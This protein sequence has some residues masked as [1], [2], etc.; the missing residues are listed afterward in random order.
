ME[1]H[2]CWSLTEN[3]NLAV[4]LDRG[5]ML[6]Y[7]NIG[8]HWLRE[9]QSARL[10]LAKEGIPECL[11]SLMRYLQNLSEFGVAVQISQ[12]RIFANIGIA[13]ETRFNADPQYM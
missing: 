6:M 13:E 9:K 11:V 7:A 2:T 4:P 1:S 3:A 10:V 12:Q 8:K 5:V